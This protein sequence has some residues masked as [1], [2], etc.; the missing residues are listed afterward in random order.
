[1]ISD[2][3]IMQYSGVVMT[4]VPLWD[5]WTGFWKIAENKLCGELKCMILRHSV[6][7]V[8]FKIQ[9]VTYY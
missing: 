3:I 9:H 4:L 7:L 5:Y 8:T 6:G 2:N 1:M